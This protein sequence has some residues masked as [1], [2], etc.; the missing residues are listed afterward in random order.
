MTEP[1]L[2]EVRG[3]VAVITINRPEQANAVN[4]AVRQGLY[5][6]FARF[7][8]DGTLLVAILTGAGN[9]VFSA[10]SDL[11]EMA[12]RGTTLLPQDHNVILGETVI[13]SK[14]VIAAVNGAAFAGGWMM[15]QSCDL[16]IA[17]ET[18]QFAITE[19]KVG[20]GMT[21][22]VPLKDMIPQRIWMEL[23]LTG[24]PM[25][26]QRAYEIGLVN[27][28][29]P[30]ERLLPKALEIAETIASN[31]PLTVRAAKEMVYLSKEMG[32]SAA[33]RA[34]EH[35]FDRVF[36]SKDAQEGPRAFREKRPPRWTGE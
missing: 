21:W 36:R 11:K 9:R 27:H 7:E 25:S 34:A 6:A 4:D 2:F 14:P 20:R 19:A 15:A 22:S 16:C 5:A 13:V 35:I 24:Q 32:T 8:S 30:S 29:V 12:E 18:A 28:V 26:A 1:V 10:G 17:S 33:R 3:G 31:A 23:L